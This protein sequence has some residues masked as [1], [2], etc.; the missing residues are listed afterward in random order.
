M[1][2]KLLRSL[3]SQRLQAFRMSYRLKKFFPDNRGHNADEKNQGLANMMQSRRS[4]A[5]IF[6]GARNKD[7]GVF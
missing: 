2:L 1:V 3:K 4:F 7:L 6:L 5:L